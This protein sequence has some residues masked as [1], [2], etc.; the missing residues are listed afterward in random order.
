MATQGA[1]KAGRIGGCF[2]LVVAVL[3]L[4]YGYLEPHIHFPAIN[5][6][7]IFAACPSSIV[8]M[9]ADSG[10]WYLVVFADSLMIVANAVWYAVWFAAA[11]K[12]LGHR[13][14]AHAST[15]ETGSHV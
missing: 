9:A 1:A 10:K 2:G 15:T 8:L 7:L 3:V 4:T 14:K 11:S 12:L 13:S 6:W 5:D